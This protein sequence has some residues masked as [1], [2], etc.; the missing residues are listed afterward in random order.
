MKSEQEI[1]AKLA[2]L[3]VRNRELSRMLEDDEIDLVTY[4]KDGT[5]IDIESTTLKWV[6][7]I[8]FWS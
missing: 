8:R 1:R 3:G 4:I 5:E 6:L 7:G 2:E